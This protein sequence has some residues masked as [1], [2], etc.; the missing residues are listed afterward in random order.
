MSRIRQRRPIPKLSEL[1]Y[2]DLTYLASIGRITW[3][4][5]NRVTHDRMIE[6][7]GGD[8]YAHLREEYR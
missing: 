1:T 7:C 2:G 6:R 3:A 5:V 8:P 4:E